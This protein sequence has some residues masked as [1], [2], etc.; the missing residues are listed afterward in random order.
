MEK[1]YVSHMD[2]RYNP[3]SMPADLSYHKFLMDRYG[4]TLEYDGFGT[5]DNIYRNDYFPDFV[6]P[7]PSDMERVHTIVNLFDAGYGEQILISQ[8]VSKKYH[9]EKYGGIGYAHILRR[10]VP[11]LRHLGLSDSEID[12][13]MIENPRRMLAFSA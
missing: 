4:V 13:L 9:L 7:T 3:L 2:G 12:M 1:V 6:R 5:Y 11:A 8:D 10:I